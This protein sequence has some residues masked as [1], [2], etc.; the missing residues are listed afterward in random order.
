V[1][2]VLWSFSFMKMPGIGRTSLGCA[3][4]FAL[5]ASAAGAQTV[6]QGSPQNAG[7][8]QGIARDP[9]PTVFAVNPSPLLNQTV[10]PRRAVLF[11]TIPAI[12]LSDGTVVAN[13][14]FGFEPVFRSC[15]GAVV[16]GEPRVVASNGVVLSQGTPTY[17]Q[18]VPAQMTAS[19]QILSSSQTRNSIAS[20]TI[21]TSATVSSLAQSACFSRTLAG[22]IIVV[23]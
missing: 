12:L 10:F 18:P 23:R 13:F 11:T 14:G 17:T 5:F 1:R 20:G 22:G 7:G 3:F 9:Q 4:A 8:Q 19:Q 21:T 15:S 16:V 6:F 2:Y